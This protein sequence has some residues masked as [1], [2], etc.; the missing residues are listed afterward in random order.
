MSAPPVLGLVTDLT[1]FPD[2]PEGLVCWSGVLRGSPDVRVNVLLDRRSGE[3]LDPVFI[4]GVCADQERLLAVAARAAGLDEGVD[5]ARWD[6]EITFR[7]G[8]NWEVRF[9]EAPGPTELGLLV[10]FDGELVAEIDDLAE[11]DF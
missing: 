10:V 1:P 3:E 6:P 2:A 8:R 7:G 4:D 5:V 11:W 9:A